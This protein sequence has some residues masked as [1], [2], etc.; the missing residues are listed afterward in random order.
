M[1]ACQHGCQQTGREVDTE[2]G[3]SS[4]E[5]ELNLRDRRRSGRLGVG[6][7]DDMT[8]S[9]ELAVCRLLTAGNL[10]TADKG[11]NS[12]PDKSGPDEDELETPSDSESISMHWG[13]IETQ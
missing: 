11:G 2:D 1:R 4:S 13:T 6:C 8:R 9:F 10:D 5:E 3:D 7:L 12:S